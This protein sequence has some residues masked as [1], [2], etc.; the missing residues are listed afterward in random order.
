MGVRRTELDKL[1]E[2]IHMIAVGK[3]EECIQE[4]VSRHEELSGLTRGRSCGP[5]KRMVEQPDGHRTA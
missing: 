4:E 3:A 2:D 5:N 1:I